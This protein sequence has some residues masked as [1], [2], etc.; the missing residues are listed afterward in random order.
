MR[1]KIIIIVLL[2]FF[3]TT[4]SFANDTLRYELLKL[5]KITV[6]TLIRL[7]MNNYVGCANLQFKKGA[8]TLINFS[9][10]QVMGYKNPSVI[11]YWTKQTST[12]NFTLA[13]GMHYKLLVVSVCRNELEND[14]FYAKYSDFA[15][16]N[17]YLKNH[18]SLEK[19]LYIGK[20]YQPTLDHYAH[21]NSRVYKVCRFNPVFAEEIKNSGYNLDFI[22]INLRK[23]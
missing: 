16:D 5:E 7:D 8:D 15:D 3:F 17:C 22:P 23:K 1:E 13:K 6:D 12:A 4:H 20:E 2:S 19:Y 9:F 14:C 11:Y 21:F 18:F 10:V